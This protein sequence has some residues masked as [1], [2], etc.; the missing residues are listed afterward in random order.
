M[1]Y[2]MQKYILKIY[3]YISMYIYTN[4]IKFIG[5]FKDRKPPF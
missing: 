4:A 3:I 1:K 2:S 5:K